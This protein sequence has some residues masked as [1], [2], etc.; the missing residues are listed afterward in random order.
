MSSDLAGSDFRF[1][2]HLT[3]PQTSQLHELYQQEWWTNTRSLEQTKQVVAHSSLLIGIVTADSRLVGFARVLTDFT[4]KALVLDVI[5]AEA[6]RDRRLG[7]ALMQRI[8]EHPK[9]RH[10]GDFELYCLPDMEAF[11]RKW[12][13]TSDIPQLRFMRF[14]RPR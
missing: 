14:R 9:L 7:Y 5:V 13:F 10:I 11:Y 2:D 4:I 3:A 12:A 6:F 8:I 1:V